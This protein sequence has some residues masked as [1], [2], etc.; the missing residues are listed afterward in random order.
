MRLNRLH[1]SRLTSR[2]AIAATVSP[3]GVFAAYLIATSLAK[4]LTD[5]AAKNKANAL[6]IEL[7]SSLDKA[8]LIKKGIPGKAINAP[9]EW[10]FI[11]MYA[12]AIKKAI[13]E[14]IVNNPDLPADVAK[15]ISFAGLMFA[16]PVKSPNYITRALVALKVLGPEYVAKFNKIVNG[17]AKSNATT[18][19]KEL[20]K[21]VKLLTGKEATL[22][23]KEA[24]DKIKEK[25]P[26][27]A[28]KYTAL[29]SKLRS[30]QVLDFL[31]Y[32]S[33]IGKPVH[34][35][36][37]NAYLDSIGYKDH[38]FPSLKAKDPLFVGANAGKIAFFTADG[39]ML[40]GGVPPA[41]NEVVF[42]STYDPKTGK[43]GYVSY[44]TPGAYGIEP[45]KLYTVDH[46]AAA[47]EEKH[48]KAEK[49]TEQL[50]KLLA[51]WTA[52]LSSRDS[53]S[54][55]SALVCLIIY[56]TGMRVST[57]KEIRSGKGVATS[58]ALT[59]KVE[60]IKLLSSSIKFKYIGKKGVAQEQVIEIKDKI[61]KLIY[62]YLKELIAGKKPSD[63]VFEDLLA[64]GK[65]KELTYQ[66]FNE[67]LKSK[68]MATGI[69]KIR[70]ALGT[71]LVNKLLVENTWKPD[72]ADKTLAK[73]Q[74]SAETFIKDKILIPVAHL[75]GHKKASGEPIWQTSIQNYV[76]P[77]PVANWFVDHKLRVP[78]WVPATATDKD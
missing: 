74:T 63:Y 52:D 5:A 32:I 29:R 4:A 42:M 27:G 54:F 38:L 17:S 2:Q 39:R 58:G 18:Q 23:P 66:K 77:Q 71:S 21:Q 65:V 16:N 35:N 51:A 20:E 11:E 45:T 8:Y 62:K 22:I 48:H 57:T 13:K 3:E 36:E 14:N 6:A 72:S 47:V 12:V 24:L 55:M 64:N 69:H 70:H 68:G 75:L 73:Q 37:A 10:P 34:V 7:Y 26:D 1:R 56:K 41:A 40:T 50:P 78:K 61:D 44:R 76:N 25:D 15:L 19:L 28:K 33:D 59:L 9:K 46:K 31:T 49:L 60:N 43:G 67:Y 30:Q 53:Y